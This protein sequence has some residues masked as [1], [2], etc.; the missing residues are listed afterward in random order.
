MDANRPR[1]IFIINPRAANGRVGRCWRS[2]RELAV[3]FLG[4]PE[5][6]F[7]YGP[8][9]GAGLAGQALAA[10]FGTVVAVGGDGTLNEVIN[11]LMAGGIAGSLR[12]KLGYLPLGTGCD[13]AR[14]LGLSR[15]P[16]RALADLAAGGEGVLDLGFASFADMAGRTGSRYFHNI[17]GIGLGGEVAGRTNNSSKLFGGFA[18]FLRAT[19][20]SLYG[21]RKEEISITVD[22]RAAWQGE[23]WH[24]A[25]ANGQYQGGGMW[26]APGAEIDDGVLRVTV[27]GNISLP[28]VV[29]NLPNLYNG[30]IFTV[31]KVYCF[32]GKKI[33]VNA[34][35]RVAVELDGEQ[36]GYL[37]LTVEVRPA[38]L[39]FVGLPVFDR[40]PG[41]LPR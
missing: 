18:S 22:G 35:K 39:R 5:F 7:T 27:V 13:M 21:Y 26:V 12:P 3:Q 17:L 1:T 30:R 4:N 33:E 14:T 38:A 11:G 31:N 23:S 32:D 24:I 20:V 41:E 36:V 40:Q 29:V 6:C 10:G 28:E 25:I 9:T 2:L 8:G 15:Q 34:D 19:L 16:E 37:P